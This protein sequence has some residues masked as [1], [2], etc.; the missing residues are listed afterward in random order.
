VLSLFAFSFF[1]FCGRFSFLLFLVDAFRFE[2]AKHTIRRLDL[3]IERQNINRTT[4]NI[5]ST[6]PIP[7]IGPTE[8]VILLFD[9]EGA[10]EPVTALL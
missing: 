5:K 1:C 9:V 8:R 3:T 7:A 6:P 2:K 10:D 4:P